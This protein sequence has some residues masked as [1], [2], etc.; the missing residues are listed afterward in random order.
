MLDV[1][2]CCEGMGAQKLV[3]LKTVSATLFDK[4]PRPYILKFEQNDMSPKPPYGQDSI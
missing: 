4:G 3:V 2:K 1:Q